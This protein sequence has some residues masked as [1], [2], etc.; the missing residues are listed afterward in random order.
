MS[1]HHK[2]K[3]P[4]A[5]LRLKDGGMPTGYQ[6]GMSVGALRVLGD[7]DTARMKNTTE[8]H[9]INT[10]AAT[11]RYGADQNR[12]ASMHGANQQLAGAK[13]SA[14]Q[15]KAASMYGSDQGRI[16]SM[17]GSDQQLAGTKISAAAARYGSDQGRIASMYGSDQGRVASMYGSDQQLAGTRINAAASQYN[18]DQGRI[19][20]MYGSDQAQK[21]SN[22]SADKN[23]QGTKYSA[24]STFRTQMMGQQMNLMMDKYKTD[25]Q[26]NSREFYS[27][28][29][30][31]NSFGSSWGQW[32]TAGSNAQSRSTDFNMNAAQSYQDRSISPGWM[33]GG[34]S[35][36]SGADMYNG[37]RYKDGG[38]LREGFG[39]VV[40]G[41]GKGDKIPAKYEPGEFV[42][43]NDMLNAQPELE[44]HLHQLRTAVLAKKGMT[45]E[46]ADAKAIK[47][48]GLRAANGFTTS[49]ANA[50]NAVKDR[51]TNAFGKGIAT[52]AN[53]PEA[54]AKKVAE[55]AA[56][57]KAAAEAAAKKATEEAAAKGATAKAQ[58]KDPVNPNVGEGR[59]SAERINFEDSQKKDTGSFKKVKAGGGTINTDIRPDYINSDRKSYEPTLRHDLE[60]KISGPTATEHA[61]AIARDAKGLAKKSGWIGAGVA[62]VD[63]A[64][65]YADPEL[66]DAEKN[67][68]LLR[69]GAAAGGALL[70]GALGKL[71]GPLAPIT[72]PMGAA[73]GYALSTELGDRLANK[74]YPDAAAVTVE[75]A[76][77]GYRGNGFDDPRDIS[78]DSSRMALGAS[79]DFTNELASVP[80]ELPKGLR[81]GVVY[82]TQTPDG[83]TAY[84]GKNVGLNPQWVDGAGRTIN[85]NAN[86]TVLPAG[87]GAAFT[88]SGP[89]WVREQA[90][91]EALLK[92]SPED[93]AYALAS[94]E[95][96]AEIA[97]E[98]QIA[99][100]EYNTMV[101][102]R[103]TMRNMQREFEQAQSVL[104]SRFTTA[105]ERQGALAIV[106]N[107][108]ALQT[109]LAAV[110]P[111]ERQPTLRE[112][113]IAQ[114]MQR[115]K[116]DSSGALQELR[117]EF[118]M[119]K[120]RQKNQVEAE[121]EEYT[122]G[123]NAAKVSYERRQKDIQMMFPD[124]PKTQ[125]DF[126]T[127]SE[128]FRAE[129]AQKAT[130]EGRP[131]LAAKIL[132]ED[133]QMDAADRKR[134]LDI[135]NLRERLKAEDGWWGG[136]KFVSSLRPKDF[137]PSDYTNNPFGI[138][139]G[140]IVT[141]GGSKAYVNDLRGRDLWGDS[142]NDFDDIIDE[143]R[144]TFNR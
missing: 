4:V 126:W 96:R 116:G 25:A 100:R 33:G 18:A 144:K 95:R 99:N 20:S 130:A 48:K 3:K 44:E 9:G 15:S 79:R 29:T 120:E 122:R 136:N 37:L 32:Q 71:G 70:G 11:S 1:T 84:S 87:A 5:S 55:E 34:G 85:P 124:D 14:D 41:R 82:K 38:Q 27:G 30:P 24:D 49:V 65:D 125:R 21:A 118:D 35:F 88:N 91:Q 102:T 8:L 2:Q 6:P 128:N 131:E 23:F 89:S 12:I 78:K 119:M 110:S 46:E 13:Y 137:M 98:N 139:A 86:L 108:A 105:A 39:G 28:R 111:Q 76:A 83:V 135:W 141:A 19:A 22:Y 69:N 45:P 90:F 72:V 47:V 31:I 138:G 53:D 113:R 133:Y 36:R 80:R 142:T 42:V 59:K 74:F 67:R 134:L 109:K 92:A 50:A 40:P 117:L 26:H 61:K 140:T 101:E 75:Q 64:M 107:Y 114:E 77:Q 56:A 58:N 10:Q 17:Y 132:R 115:G 121:K 63:T 60:T 57:K 62:A 143:A 103:E 106:E 54:A 68:N 123:E 66:S 104:A 97:Q 16:A 94:P 93:R 52:P 127:F 43:S 51:V 112:Q 7:A 129:I 73:A 81:E